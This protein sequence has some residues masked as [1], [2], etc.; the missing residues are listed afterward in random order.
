MTTVTIVAEN[1]GSPDAA[2]RASAR[3]HE[4]VGRT[5]GAALDELTRQLTDAEAGT[6]VV[7]Q[8]FRPDSFFSAAQ[9]SRLQELLAEWRSARSAGRPMPPEQQ[10]E[11][12]DL[13]G[14]ELDASAARSGAMARDLQP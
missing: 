10:K 1:P 3:D 11:L 4:S 9:Q 8:N 2:F 7:V 5:P 13:V 14:T 12:E 6:L